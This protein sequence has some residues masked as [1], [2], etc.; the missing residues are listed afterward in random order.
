MTLASAATSHAAGLLNRFGATDAVMTSVDRT[1]ASLER[2]TE[3]LGERLPLA[4][5]R[6]LHLAVPEAECMKLE[7]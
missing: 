7:N 6:T 5:T 2:L 1:Y 4:E 3:T